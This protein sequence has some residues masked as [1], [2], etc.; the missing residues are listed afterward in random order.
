M[1]RV[2]IV[3]PRLHRHTFTGGILCIFEYAKGLH[4]RGHEVSVVPLL[5]SPYPRWVNGSFGRL[6]L[7]PVRQPV[8]QEAPRA[9]VAGRQGL[10]SAVRNLAATGGVHVA[11]YFPRE[12]QRGFQLYFVRERLPP[13]DVTVATSF[14]T[15]LPVHLFGM[16]RRCYFM[17]HFEPLFAVDSPNPEWLRH[18]ALASYRLGLHMI[19]NSRWLRDTVREQTGIE[20]QLCPNAIDHSIFRLDA[21]AKPSSGE[22]HIISYGGGA[23]SWKGFREMA[24]AVRDV[25]SAMRGNRIKWSVFGPC[26]LPPRNDIADYEPLGFLRPEELARAYCSSDILLSASWYESFP[27]FPLEAMACGLAVITTQPGTEEF[28][29]HGRTAE[30]VQPRDVNSI[31]AGLRRLID[32]A[33][34]R[35]RLADNGRLEAQRFSWTHAVDRMEKL[36]L[37]PDPTDAVGVKS[38]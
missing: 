28:A 33:E 24:G 38:G 21:R 4:Q 27:L 13:A 2:N 19:A 23:A 10:I 14:E 29:L 32:D 7:R 37:E 22:I 35:C 9:S 34:Y 3:V 36:L 26:L 6:Q 17:Q 8:D 30:I 1:A 12:V 11:R 16:G 25:R 18:E 15:A 20:P 31:A 5:P